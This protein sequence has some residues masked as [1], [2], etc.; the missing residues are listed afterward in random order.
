M[1]P[2]R[3]SLTE[4]TLALTEC[5]WTKILKGANGKATWRR[6]V[7]QELLQISTKWNTPQI[8]P[9]RDQWKALYLEAQVKYNRNIRT[10]QKRI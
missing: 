9:H 10:T 7:L 2:Y 1:K 4:G 5:P 6:S 3:K 8:A